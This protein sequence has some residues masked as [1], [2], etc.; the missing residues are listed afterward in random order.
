MVDN[1]KFPKL[2]NKL[3]IH[4]VDFYS[5]DTVLSSEGF[6]G[7]LPSCSLDESYRT[8]QTGSVFRRM[9]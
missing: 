8:I 6:A 4:T 1:F 5:A 7:S 9:L 3:F 2:N